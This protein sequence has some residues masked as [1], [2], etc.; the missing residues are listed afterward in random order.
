MLRLIS[1]HTLDN[2]NSLI[3]LWKLKTFLFS[4]CAANH[5]QAHNQGREICDGQESIASTRIHV[6]GLGGIGK[7]IAHSLK[8]IPSSP[9]VTL[10]FHR[11]DLVDLWTQRG[12]KIVIKTGTNKHA[13]R[14]YETELVSST[15]LQ[16]TP[17]NRII[18]HLVVT[19]NAHATIPAIKAVKDRLRPE[20]TILLIQTG[21]GLLE[22]INEKLFPDPETR[23]NYMLGVST[24]VVFPLGGFQAFH[25]GFGTTALCMLSKGPPTGYWAPTSRYLMSTLTRIPVLA[26][27]GFPEAVLKQ[28]QLERLAVDAIINPLTLLFN[29]H[30]G[31]LLHNFA[32]SNVMDLLISEV[33]LILRSLPELRDLPHIH[34]RFS[35]GR[36]RQL[37]LAVASTTSQNISPMLRLARAGRET[38]IDYINGYITKRARELGLECGMNTM[39]IQ[40]AKGKQQLLYR[41]REDYVAF[42]EADHGI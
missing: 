6:L 24:H 12:Q 34:K 38:E 14:G 16:Q 8:G 40:M 20:S 4:T 10:V 33:S 26:A 31:D 25:T 19:T 7:L 11:P 32:I 1:S 9:P 21:M 22:E 17:N 35:P 15:A 23:P 3:T 13:R 36:L 30:N 28:L 27:V 5:T 37:V 39:V 41:Q 18:H 2:R 42:Q 29:C